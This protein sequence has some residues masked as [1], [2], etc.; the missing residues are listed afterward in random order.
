MWLFPVTYPIHIAEEYWA[1]EGFPAWVSRVAG[2]GLTPTQFLILNGVAWV[3]MVAG[4]VLVVKTAS[5]HWL[6]ISFSTV[7]LLNGLL[8]FSASVVT[9]SYSPGLVSGMLL[10]VPLGAFFLF[11][12][13][14]GTQRRTFLSAA[15]IGIAIHGVVSLLAFYPGRIIDLLQQSRRD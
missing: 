11:R 3:L 15:L 2:V 4:S 12:S 8:H 14:A 13:W 1:G 6:L 5:M 7:V 10:W 9:D